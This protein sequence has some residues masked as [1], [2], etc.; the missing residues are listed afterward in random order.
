MASL[1][2]RLNILVDAELEFN[3]HVSISSTRTGLA[4]RPA[5]ACQAGCVC[6]SAPK[7]S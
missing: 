1:T 6:M 5:V 3:D 4:S 2:P 7:A